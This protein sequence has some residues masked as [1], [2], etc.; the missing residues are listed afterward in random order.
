MKPDSHLGHLSPF[1]RQ[2]WFADTIYNN[3]TSC[4]WRQENETKKQ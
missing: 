1:Q 3:T 4:D 2:E